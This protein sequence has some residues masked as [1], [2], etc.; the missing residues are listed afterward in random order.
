MRCSLCW[1]SRATSQEADRFANISYLPLKPN[2]FHL[3]F[4]FTL[5][6]VSVL[7]LGTCAEGL[8][9]LF[10]FCYCHSFF[11]LP[12]I[13]SSNWEDLP[14]II[15]SLFS[16]YNTI[17]V[18]SCFF[19]EQSPNHSLL[20]A[21]RSPPW[22]GPTPDHILHQPSLISTAIKEHVLQTAHYVANQKKHGMIGSHGDIV[23][24]SPELGS[25]PFFLQ[26]Y[27]I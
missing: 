19:W 9:L 20:S 24:H 17:I 22:S 7:D 10:I 11:Y 15:C 16:T 27:T 25:L 3:V 14:S 1:K 6:C 2:V 18:S 13:T 8:R 26:K 23:S 5:F 12:L 4:T 21:T